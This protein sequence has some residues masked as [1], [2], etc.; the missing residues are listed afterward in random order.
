MTSPSTQLTVLEQQISPILA[1]VEQ[2]AERIQKLVPKGMTSSYY[3]EELR[4]YLSQPDKDGKPSKLLSCEPVSIA[5]GIL[6]VATTGLSLG[7]SCDLLPFGK[8]CQYNSRY[9]GLIE[10]GLSAGMREVDFDVVYDDD[11]VWEFEKGTN[12][13]LR[14]R[15]GPRK[16]KPTH[17]YTIAEIKQGSF[18]FDV[19]TFEEVEAHK[20]KYSQQWKN[21]PLKDCLWYGTKTTTRRNSKKWPKN[22]RLNAA[23]QFDKEVEPDADIDDD[24]PEGEFSVVEEPGTPTPVPVSSKAS[25]TPEPAAPTEAPAPAVETALDRAKKVVLPG[26]QTAWNNQGGKLLD[27]FSSGH[28]DSIKRWCIAKIKADGDNEDLQLVSDAVTLI[29]EDRDRNQA[30][31]DLD[32]QKPA[33]RKAAATSYPGDEWSPDSAAGRAENEERAAKVGL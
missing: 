27:S 15:R 25:P 7:V 10:L 17:F 22:A 2:Y 5:R 11:L 32:A 28:L 33:T 14:H 26:P 3:V 23:L 31:L 18:V 21:T 30:K 29:L 1:V 8:T 13:F 6:R 20:A 9:T 19:M 16:G 24:I 12:P 4:L